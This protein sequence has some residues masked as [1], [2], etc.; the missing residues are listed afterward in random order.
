M[1]FRPT[2]VD[3]VKE[4]LRSRGSA[5][6]GADTFEDVE[7]CATLTTPAGSPAFSNSDTM[8]SV[9]RG[10]SAGGLIT[11]VHP[12]ASAGAILRVAIANGKFRG[13]MKNDGPTGRWDTTMRPVP[14]GLMP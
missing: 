2:S 9:V 13:V 11:T 8:K 1:S 12:A 7:V 6:I 10:V 14:S 3:P 4:S 5:M